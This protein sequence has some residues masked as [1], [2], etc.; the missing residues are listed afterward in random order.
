MDGIGLGG[1]FVAGDNG[2]GRGKGAVRERDAG[3]GRAGN[4]AGDAGH[5]LK[6][7]ASIH[8]F[9][10]FFAATAK[11]IG[12]ATLEAGNDL[13]FLRLGDEELVDI[14]LLHGVVARDLADVDEFSVGAGNGEQFIAGKVVVNHHVSFGKDFS[15]F[16]GE[17][18]GIAGAC[19][20]EIN[21]HP[22]SGS[23]IRAHCTY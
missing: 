22:S 19:A 12:I 21:V 13:A 16:A 3:I 11:Y 23:W 14:A 6:G 7:N 5:F 2:H 1:V 18:A 9:F 10:G 8:E 4:G 17:Q 15:A 20:D